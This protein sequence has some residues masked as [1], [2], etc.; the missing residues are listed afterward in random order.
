MFEKIKRF[1]IGGWESMRGYNDTVVAQNDNS[2]EVSYWASIYSG[3]PNW[4]SEIAM[5]G[6]SAESMNV[7][8]SVCAELA[9]LTT[10]ELEGKVLGE[11]ASIEFLD[12]KLQK[13]L[14]KLRENTEYALALGGMVIKPFIIGNHNG[15]AF[16]GKDIGFEFY[17]PERFSPITFNKEGQLVS[18]AF[19]DRL[20]KERNFYTR[21][22]THSLEEEGS[23][24]IENRVY[25][26][27]SL[28]SKGT[29]VSLQDIEEWKDI[30]PF[31]GFSGIT[32]PLFVY[33]KPPY[34]NNDDPNSNLGTSVLSKIDKFLKDADETWYDI[35]W[36]YNSKRAVVH[37]SNDLV[38]YDE[39]LKPKLSS[40]DRK[41]FVIL[42]PGKSE[43]SFIKTP[44][45]DMRDE[46]LFNKL[47]QTMREIEINA[48]LAYG[49]L[50]EV[51]QVEKTAEEIRSSKERSY[52]TVHDIQKALEVSIKELI[53]V[54]NIISSLKND[55]LG[56]YIDGYKEPKSY[57]V[58]LV[59]DDSIVVESKNKKLELVK[60]EISLGLIAPE[61]YLMEKYNI[62]QEEA[63]KML[64]KKNI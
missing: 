34:S 36:E 7:A 14:P 43:D 6:D 35:Q 38:G 25:K 9:R 48:G 21:V 46:S 50:S 64:P 22:E 3:K 54:V 29:E 1:F 13:L 42:E 49:T 12:N 39:D 63:I 23:Y 28:Y 24:T 57:E 27:E 17:T 51:D 58:S 47:N 62:S 45:D 26:S 16:V 59:F 33:F 5:E 61:F 19:F 32:Q 53:S 11:G 41:R 52:S 20:K 30:E 55:E 15:K 37:I 18:A 2:K 10:I 31:V 60:E 4:L 44:S 40:R 56:S 8:A